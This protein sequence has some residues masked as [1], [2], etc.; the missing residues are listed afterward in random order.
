VSSRALHVRFEDR[1]PD[2]H[3]TYML[4]IATGGGLMVYSSALATRVYRHFEVDYKVDTRALMTM[5]SRSA[6]SGVDQQ[7]LLTQRMI[8]Q[9]SF[10]L[11]RSLLSLTSR[12]PFAL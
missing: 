3:G 7:R 10:F 2:S 9:V 6:A 11:Y 8:R 12:S 1:P 4:S 5:I